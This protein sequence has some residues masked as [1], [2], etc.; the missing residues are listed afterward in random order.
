MKNQMI[1]V[2]YNFVLTLGLTAADDFE[3]RDAIVSA[4]QNSEAIPGE[5]DDYGQRYSLDFS[6]RRRGREAIK[7]TTWIIRIGEDAPRLTSCY[8]L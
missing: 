8:V 7:H 4:I 1:V 5:R 3:L 6:M 2:R